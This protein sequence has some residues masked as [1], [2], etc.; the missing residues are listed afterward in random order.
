[1][2]HIS[3]ARSLA[4]C[5]LCAVSLAA[6][7]P[8]YASL[9]DFRLENGQTI[10]ECRI[11][12]RTFGTL[13][14]ARSNAILFPTWFTGTSKDLA[15]LIGPGKL[16]DPTQHFVIAVDALGNGVSTSPSNSKRQPGMQFPAFSIRDM[17]ESQHRLLTGVLDIQHLRAVMGISMGGMQTFQWMISHPDFMD[18]AIPIVGSPQLTSY[19]L[20]LWNAELHALDAAPKEKAMP[21][22]AD[23]HALAI[24]TPEDRLRQTSRADFAKYLA[25]TEQRTMRGFDRDNWYRQLQA[26]I[27]HDVAAR[28]GGSLQAAAKTT[29]ARTLVIVGLADHMVNPQPALLFA[30]LVNAQTLEL[31]SNCGHLVPGCEPEKISRTIAAFLLK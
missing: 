17:V 12:Y 6:Q 11:S 14:A 8:Q 19:D 20:L 5:I 26:M 9:G 29:R 3:M 22:V 7:E 2:V 28:H 30:R 13:N 23:I 24:S 16:I 27:G 21:V 1:M 18:C 25:D 4:A 31:D 10:R 15:G